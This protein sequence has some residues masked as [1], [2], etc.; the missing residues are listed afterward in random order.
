MTDSDHI[1]VQGKQWADCD[2]VKVSEVRTKFTMKIFD[3]RPGLLSCLGGFLLSLALSL[4]YSYPN[5]NTYVT[6]YLRQN[7]SDN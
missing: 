3:C 7:G 5:L 2:C 6:S 1:S 4:D